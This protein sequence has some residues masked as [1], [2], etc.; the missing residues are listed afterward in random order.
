VT[1]RP[2]APRE[3]AFVREA[4][5]VST[6]D[7]YAWMKVRDD[8]RLLENLVAERAYYHAVTARLAGMVDTLRA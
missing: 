7:P 3:E 1:E 4:H 2:V 8:P 6:P 5:G